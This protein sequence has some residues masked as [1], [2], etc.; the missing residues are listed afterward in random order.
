MAELSQQ[1]FYWHERR[2]VSTDR[3]QSPT[4]SLHHHG[5]TGR[6]AYQRRKSDA[7]LGGTD[8][9]EKPIWFAALTIILFSVLDFIFTTIILESGGRELNLFM[10]H[11][12]K[13]GKGAFFATKYCLTALAVH[14]LLAN[15]QQ[16]IFKL[17]KVNTVLYAFVL[18][19]FSL[20]LY[21][22]HLIASI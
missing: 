21:E 18:A 20:L 4:R 16:I 9:F 14:I 11:V 3:R 8:H 13:D 10:N 1:E 22:I 17:I 2:S 12:I 5:L 15:H 7:L 19:Y 6:R